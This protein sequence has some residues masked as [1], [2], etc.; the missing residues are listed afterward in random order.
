[1]GR[2]RRPDL[3]RTVSRRAE[4][5]DARPRSRACH[6][7]S[8]AQAR[9]RPRGASP[10]PHA[11]QGRRAA[12]LTGALFLEV[13]SGRARLRDSRLRRYLHV[14]YRRPEPSAI[15]LFGAGVVGLAMA[16]EKHKAG[17]LSDLD[18]RHSG[19]RRYQCFGRHWRPARIDQERLE[20]MGLM[21]K[22]AEEQSV[23]QLVEPMID[24]QDFILSRA[25]GPMREIVENQ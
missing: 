25:H 22:G 16:A 19:L 8:R 15:L 21:E 9:P 17:T 20:V 7:R 5:A 4:R 11:S 18:D 23:M 3:A 13:R 14:Q 1:M 10:Y 2:R 12:A 24:I 6:R